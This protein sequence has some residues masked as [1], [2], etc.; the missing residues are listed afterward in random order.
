MDRDRATL[1]APSLYT[2]DTLPWGVGDVLARG[3]CA[4]QLLSIG[5]GAQQPHLKVFTPLI[6]L[7]PVDENLVLQGRKVTAHPSAT[8][9]GQRAP[10]H[11]G[12]G[13]D[14]AEPPAKQETPPSRKKYLPKPIN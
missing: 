9:Q 10:E 2:E 14:E 4:L 7:A 12:A 3:R 6:L 8:E 5:E 11:W 13:A 1:P